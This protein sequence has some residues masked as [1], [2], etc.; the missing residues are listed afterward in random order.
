[1]KTILTQDEYQNQFVDFYRQTLGTGIG[2][3]VG[4]VDD[5]DEQDDGST[6][7]NVRDVGG[8]DVFNPMA[9]T[10]IFTGGPSYNATNISAG[11]YVRNNSKSAKKQ[12]DKSFSG[13]KDYMSQQLQKPETAVL[14]VA[15]VMLRRS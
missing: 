4:P 5:D 8:G 3:T 15:G 14:A 12:M 2:T 1:M 10:N 6:R 13:F 11:D 9:G 7:P